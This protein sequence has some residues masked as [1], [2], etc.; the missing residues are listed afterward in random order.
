[1][2]PAVAECIFR[3]MTRSPNGSDFFRAFDRDFHRLVLGMIP[4]DVLDKAAESLIEPD[5]VKSAAE[6]EKEKKAVEAALLKAK[7]TVFDKIPSE[8]MGP[9][10]DD[11]YRSD[12]WE[13]FVEW[14][15]LQKQ[16]DRPVDPFDQLCESENPFFSAWEFLGLKVPQPETGH[17]FTPAI[18]DPTNF[19]V[20]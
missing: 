16:M 14:L 10:G 8:I 9:N 18:F 6:R 13:C 20:A 3:T 12:A 17:R 11:F 19:R 2:L 7:K 1:M 15:N 5:G 4:D